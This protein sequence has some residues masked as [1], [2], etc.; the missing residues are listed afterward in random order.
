MTTT[1][2]AD[3]TLPEIGKLI[4]KVNDTLSDYVWAE[5]EA[6]KT[7]HALAEAQLSWGHFQQNCSK[8]YLEYPR[9]A[10]DVETLRRL[11]AECVKLSEQVGRA[12]LYAAEA[13]NSLAGRTGRLL[14]LWREYEKHAAKGKK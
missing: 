3:V 6:R 14:W 10:G 5:Q 9:D 8:R 1:K 4:V 7:S 2:D 13:F 12:R 11:Q